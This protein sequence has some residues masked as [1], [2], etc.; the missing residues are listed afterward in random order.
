MKRSLLSFLLLPYICFSQYTLIPDQNFEQVLV[1]LGYDSVVN[2]KVPTSNITG[3]TH[4]LI[5]NKAVSDLTGI[6]SFSS[7]QWLDCKD[8]SLLELD[9]TNNDSLLY[10]DCANNLLNHLKLG[11][12]LNELRCYSNN[13]TSLDLSNSIDLTFLNCSNTRLE[14]LNVKNGYNENFVGFYTSP[15]TYLDCIKTDNSFGITIAF[16]S[17]DHWTSFD[18]VCNYPSSCFGTTLIEEKVVDINIYP[19]PTNG[20]VNIVCENHPDLIKTELYNINGKLLKVDNRIAVD[21]NEF[22]TGIYLL[23]VYF[24]GRIQD[25]KIFKN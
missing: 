25:F 12:S 2:G 21:L 20:I 15:N 23:R 8:N 17:I 13:I 22:E 18:T 6:E 9:L 19:N 4:L 11:T 7:L 1:D 24:N 3:I 16:S 10:L 5:G 14:C